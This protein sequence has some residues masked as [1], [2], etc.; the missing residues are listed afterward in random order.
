MSSRGGQRNHEWLKQCSVCGRAGHEA[1][2]CFKVIGYPEWWGDRPKHRVDIRGSQ[3]TSAGRGRGYT[4]R[5]NVT[6]INTDAVGSSTEL[7]EHDR[8]GL[9]GLSDEQW[10]A[11]QKLINSG[12]SATSLSGKTHDTLWILDT[13]ATHHMT[14]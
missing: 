2:A 5:D 10:N 1:S 4:P 13:G 7:T 6:Q 14:G 12:K 3:T 11:I 8:Q 9:C